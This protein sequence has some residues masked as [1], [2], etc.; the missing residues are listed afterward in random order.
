MPKV[1]IGNPSLDVEQSSLRLWRRVS[2]GT[3]RSVG[4][5]AQ[6]A[7]YGSQRSRGRACVDFGFAL[8]M[9]N[10]GNYPR[11]NRM[12]VSLSMNGQNDRTAAPIRGRCRRTLL[13][14]YLT[15]M[16]ILSDTSGGLNGT[17]R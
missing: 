14:Y 3:R 9:M 17:W 8:K 15:V 16:V 4:R 2:A 13:A 5:P 10:K 1:A 11:A 12:Q 7:G 6:R